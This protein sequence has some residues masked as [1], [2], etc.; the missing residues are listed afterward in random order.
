MDDASVSVLSLPEN[1]L[2]LLFSVSNSSTLEKAVEIL[3]EAS[4][5]ADGRS[6]LASKNVLPAVLQLCQNLSDP[7][8]SH[9]LLLS[10]KLLRNLCAG[11][12]ANQTLFI[13][14][15]GVG[16]VLAALNSLRLA[17]DLDYGIIRMGLQI[18]ANVSLAGEKHQR[19]IWHL[20]FPYKFVEI[21]S[22]QRKET[23]DPLCMVIYTCC[24][25]S[26][27]LFAELC[28]DQGLPIMA[29]IVRTASA[30]G[31]GED[32]LKLLLSRICLE[33]NQLPC[34][35]S[36]LWPV[37][38]SENLEDIK[39]R[40]G[41]FVSEQA[42]LLNILSEILNE[43][44]E[45]ISI[46]NDFALYVLGLLKQAVGVLDSVSRGKSSLPTGS[47]SLD[48]LGYSLTILRDICACD[49]IGDFT[50][51]SLDVVDSL[52]S[53]G[54]LELLLCLLRDLEP[55]TVIRKAMKQDEN[56]E[57]TSYSYKRCPYKGFR[58]DIVA[59]IGNCAYKR[60]HVQDEIRQKNGILLL[61]QQCVIDED[62]PFLREWGIWSVRNLLEGNA[63][64]QRVVAEL[65]LQGSVD[66]PEIAR[67][68]LRVEFDEKSRRAKL[69]NVS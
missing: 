60:K 52:V 47:I 6:D 65:E 51:V 48:V 69:V 22:V 36:K 45:E 20:L 33:E 49:S 39:I 18:L 59:V 40:D 41:V 17:S 32:W 62:N 44:I 12:V 61:L 34:L 64:N 55:P 8:A 7:S 31:F 3:I 1:V 54:L 13:E 37:G 21:A 66:V 50:K 30:V 53:S 68:G 42:F 14:Q 63:E 23:C 35:F 26:H 25:G 9:L 2:E 57:G 11:E 28:G 19:A 43:R 38:G 16:I 58:R 4:R 46:S 15:N 24:D 29:E 67:L 5:S 27:G 10:L 56:Q